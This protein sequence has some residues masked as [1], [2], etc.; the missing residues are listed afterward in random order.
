M[1]LYYHV[2]GLVPIDQLGNRILTNQTKG[3][4]RFCGNQVAEGFTTGF[5]PT[6]NVICT[7]GGAL[8][9]LVYSV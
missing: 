2:L 8:A 9:K 1:G 3:T 6:G 7:T 4:I 5:S